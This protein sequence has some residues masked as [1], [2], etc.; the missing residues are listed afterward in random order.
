MNLS[1]E[2]KAALLFE[3]EDDLTPLSLWQSENPGKKPEDF[4]GLTVEVLDDGSG[5]YVPF[6]VKANVGKMKRKRQR[7]Y[8][9]EKV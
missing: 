3:V 1:K 9:V 6:V 4:D 2:E 5:N 7:E 8:G